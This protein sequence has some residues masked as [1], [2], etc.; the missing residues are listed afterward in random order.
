MTGT[1]G[2]PIIIISGDTV[3]YRGYD[4]AEAIAAITAAHGKS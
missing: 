1:D 4:L 2:S 3:I